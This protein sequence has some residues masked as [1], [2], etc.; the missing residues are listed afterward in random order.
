MLSYFEFKLSFSAHMPGYLLTFKNF[1]YAKF[2]AYL[3]K[4]LGA[5]TNYIIHDWGLIENDHIGQQRGT[6]ERW[7]CQDIW[8][9]FKQSDP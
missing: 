1:E 6:N 5:F 3:F 8:P 7:Q 2:W 9:S 4:R